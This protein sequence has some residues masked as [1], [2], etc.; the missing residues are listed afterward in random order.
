MSSTNTPSATERP[1]P[2]QGLLPKQATG[3]DAFL[4]RFP[5]YDGRGVRVAVLDTGVDPAALGLD[6]PNK[7]VDVIDCSGAGD[8]PL[9]PVEARRTED[10]TALALVSPTT[11]R[12]LLVSP[13]WTNPSGVWKVGTKRAYDLWPSELVKRRTEQRREAFDVSHAALVQGVQCELAEAQ[14]DAARTTELQTRLDVLRELR[15]AWKDPGPILEAVVFHDGTH[16]RAA[17]GGG[18]GEPADP[19]A[20]EPAALRAGEVD[21]R[22]AQLLTDFRTERAWSCF[23]AMDLL[24]YTVNI[25]D[26][27]NLLSLVTLSGTHGTHVAGII[28]A[29]SAEA[30]TNGVAPGAE[31]VSLRIGDGRLGGMEQ[32]QALLRAAQA[33]IDTRCDVANM[34]FGED[35]ALGVENRGAFADALRTVIDEHG[36]CFVSSAGNDGPALSTVGHPGGTTSGVLSVGAYVTAGDMQQAEYA[37]VESGVPSSVTTWCSRG[38]TA[39]GDAG[40]SVYAPGAAITSICR[41]ALQSKQL[42]NGTSM[43]SPSAAGAVALLVSGLKAQGRRVSPARVFAALRETGEDVGDELGVRLLNVDRAW[44]YLEAHADDAY[45]DVPMRVRVTRAGKP[46]GA[47]D[48]RGVYLREAPETGRLNQVQVHVQPRFRRAETERAFALEVRARLETSAPW[49]EAP[50]FLVVGANGRAFEARVAAHTLAPGL[51]VGWV[52]AYDTERGTKL[53]EVPV[54][55]AKPHVLDAPTFAYPPVRLAAGAVERQF[56]E[57][58]HGATWAEVRVCSRAHETRGAAV[59]FWLHL[60]QLVP[61]A[62]RSKIEHAFVMALHENEPVVKRVAVEGGRT[63]EVCAAQFWASRAGFDVDLTLEF[64]G[65]D[66][67]ASL[68]R[69]VTLAG[70]DGLQRVDATSRVRPEECK[71]SATLDT[72]RTYV[73]PTQSTVRPLPA[74]R[75]RV[76]SGRQLSEL[77]LEYPV[78]VTEASSTLTLRLPVSDTLYDNAV[79]L[80]TQL[81]DVEGATVA[82]GDV[83]P[84]E[85][86][87]A[88]GE[89]TLRAQLL[90]DDDAV[91]ERLRTLTL[92]VDEKLTKP[93]EVALD[94]YADHVA[95]FGTPAPDAPPA[96]LDAVKLFPGERRVLCIDASLEGERRPAAAAPGD[97]LLGTL[98]LGAHDKHPLR[99]VV[100]PAPAPSKAPEG[101]PAAETRAK[102]PALL[103]GLVPKLDGDE[104][105]RFLAT[106]VAEHPDDLDVLVAQLEAIPADAPE[107]AERTLAAA[108]ALLAAVD[109][110][111]LLRWRGAKHPPAAEQSA[112]EKAAHQRRDAELRALELALV[113]RARAHLLRDDAPAFDAALQ[114]ARTFLEDTGS[115]GAAQTMHAN[116]VIEWHL[117][118][119]RLGAALRALRQQL[120][121][122]GRGT[123]DTRDALRRAHALHLDLLA[124][125]GWD[126][127]HHHHARWAWLARPAAPAPF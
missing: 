107:D 23:G 31:I 28:A 62:R 34:S 116:L 29:R 76:P 16:W 84:K 64:H 18:E 68:A 6:G 88:R 118:H 63:L 91:L 95:A 73:R 30:A 42:M 1:F 54:T 19:A 104:Q 89:Y 71:P 20:G 48:A 113:R 49:I 101:A 21:L 108:D 69:P 14:G 52:R 4:K 44:D 51:H 86:T 35:G 123:R 45:A 59:R 99:V 43:S 5:E 65:L 92:A 85:Q 60:L 17:V 11:Q 127:W 61:H 10:G 98:A 102:L 12:T 67:G 8:V 40:V 103:A 38:P 53:F 125:L 97:L 120:E 58:P 81:V 13:E 121:T 96:K 39:D 9:T 66:V 24:T 111:A 126:V 83:Y 122:L 82:F 46:P 78:R 27:G 105:R 15:K 25:L 26:D 75:D 77:L 100:P 37:L 32:G 72:R 115:S 124:R 41:Y 70:G 3:A 22:G 119:A 33:M 93:K 110:P 79:A 117:R 36:V 2:V 94:V 80:L 7:V 47:A 57:V 50:D 109:E 55:V 56:V 87:L 106:L 114:H 74:P 112:E 90:H